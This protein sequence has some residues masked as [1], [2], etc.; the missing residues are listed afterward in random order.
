MYADSKAIA[1]ICL[2]AY[3]TWHLHA[4]LQ[5]IGRYTRLYIIADLGKLRND[6][7]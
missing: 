1:H 6:I 7:S 4:I 2:T 5:H 3:I